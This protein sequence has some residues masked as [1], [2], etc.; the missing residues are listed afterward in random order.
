[1]LLGLPILGGHLQ[2]VEGGRQEKVIPAR[3]GKREKQSTS[4]KRHARFKLRVPSL[5]AVQIS[6]TFGEQVANTIYTN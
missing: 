3:M 4:S 1:V 6:V 2:E 5:V